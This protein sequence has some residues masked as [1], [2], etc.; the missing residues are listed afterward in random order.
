MTADAQ[1]TAALTTKRAELEKELADLSAPAEDQGGISFGKRV[2]DGTSMAVERL[3]Q[4]AVHEQ[5]QETLGQVD[6]AL[7]KV[8]EGSYGRCDGCGGPIPGGRLEALPWA[9]VCVDCAGGR[10]HDHQFRT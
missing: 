6:R 3:S 1:K 4:V 5:L 10:S 8:A 9:S 7:V 2:G